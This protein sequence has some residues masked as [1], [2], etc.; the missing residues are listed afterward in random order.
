M[1]GKVCDVSSVMTKL[2]FTCNAPR[3]VEQFDS[4]FLASCNNEETSTNSGRSDLQ[5][6][7]TKTLS[8]N[9]RQPD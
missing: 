5:K 7:C 9:W 6:T 3:G 2:S 4:S 1:A 8:G